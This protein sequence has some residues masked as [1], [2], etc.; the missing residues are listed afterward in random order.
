MIVFVLLYSKARVL[1]Q[2]V[3]RRKLLSY[4]YND[5]KFPNKFSLNKTFITSFGEWTSYSCKEGSIAP[6]FYCIGVETLTNLTPYNFR[7]PCWLRVTAFI[8]HTHTAGIRLFLAGTRKNSVIE[9][10]LLLCIIPI[11][12]SQKVLRWRQSMTYWTKL[13]TL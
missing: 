4:T 6:N 10:R 11:S 8:V 1:L 13:E 12:D 3:Q 9:L 2:S 7:H 5:G